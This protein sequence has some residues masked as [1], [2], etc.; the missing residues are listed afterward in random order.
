MRPFFLRIT[1]TATTPNLS[2]GM[3]EH[4]KE[5]NLML[6]AVGD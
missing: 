1:V 3:R 6:N 2:H 5:S 4:L